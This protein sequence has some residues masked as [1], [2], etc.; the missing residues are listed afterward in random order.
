MKKTIVRGGGGVGWGGGVSRM[1][2]RESRSAISLKF[3]A[4]SIS[5]LSIEIAAF[6]DHSYTDLV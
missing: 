5:R 1:G 4:K 2:A 3:S 6:S